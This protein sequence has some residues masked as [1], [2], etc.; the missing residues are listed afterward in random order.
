M[1]NAA[2][3]PR[4]TKLPQAPPGSGHPAEHLTPRQPLPVSP[5]AERETASVCELQ[6]KCLLLLPFPLLPPSS[7]ASLSFGRQQHWRSEQRRALA[8]D[9]LPPPPPDPSYPPPSLPIQTGSRFSPL[10]PGMRRERGGGYSLRP[11]GLL[12]SLE[13]G[14]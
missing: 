4:P 9:P 13:R 10:G 3:L 8:Q 6:P 2:S 1:V 7:C 11:I 14:S 5:R 12:C